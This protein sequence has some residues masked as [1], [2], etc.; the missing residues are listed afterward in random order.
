MMVTI[1]VDAKAEAGTPVSLDACLEATFQEGVIEGYNC[2]FCNKPTMVKDRKRFITYPSV[3]A[4]ALK[5]IVHDGYLPQKVLAELV[6]DMNST[7]DMKRYEGNNA[8][9]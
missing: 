2:P 3:F 9:L 4:F 7:V 6:L 1:P 5:R 8:E